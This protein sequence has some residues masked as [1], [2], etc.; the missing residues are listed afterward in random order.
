[1]N[2][3]FV[4]VNPPVLTLLLDWDLVTYINK[5]WHHLFIGSL[6]SFRNVDIHAG[7]VLVVFVLQSI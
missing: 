4:N 3:H 6:L 5:S 7:L 2:K 1:M